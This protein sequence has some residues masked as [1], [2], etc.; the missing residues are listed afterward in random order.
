MAVLREL[1]TPSTCTA[2][3][4]KT[5]SSN[6]A[7]N[8]VPGVAAAVHFLPSPVKPDLHAQVK[9]PFVLVQVASFEQSCAPVLHSSTSV[10]E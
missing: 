10:G 8:Q 2:D 1:V 6:D 5:H 7:S 3:D 4:D 9:L